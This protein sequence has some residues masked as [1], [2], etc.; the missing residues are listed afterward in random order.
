M[1]EVKPAPGIKVSAEAYEAVMRNSSGN[2]TKED[3]DTFF[4]KFPEQQKVAEHIPM[5]AMYRFVAEITEACCYL[6]VDVGDVYVFSDLGLLDTDRTTGP[7]CPW[8]IGEMSKVM[9]MYWDR[10]CANADPNEC[11]WTTGE[12]PDRGMKHGGFGKVK[13]TFRAEVK[14]KEEWNVDVGKCRLIK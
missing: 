13:F 3:L 12:C 8:I 1:S 11:F 5:L 2:V 14:P 9:I 6:G 7:L 4:K 10:I